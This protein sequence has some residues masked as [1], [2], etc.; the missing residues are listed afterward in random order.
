MLF[1]VCVL[2]GFVS[3]ANG[4]PLHSTRA[5]LETK[6]DDG[7][8][9]VGWYS[10]PQVRGTFDLLL[11]CLTT[12]SLCAWTAYH[13]NVHAHRS[14]WKVLSHRA[15]WML[16]A[17]LF[18]EV[19]LWCAWEQWWAA[20]KLGNEINVL[21]EGA[22]DGVGS[23]G[24]EKAECDVCD[25]AEGDEDDGKMSL[26]DY[27][28]NLLFEENGS[29]PASQPLTDSREQIAELKTSGP[30]KKPVSP[31]IRVRKVFKI[32]RKT[33]EKDNR[34]ANWTTSQAFFALSGGF[35]VPSSNFHPSPQ[36]TLTSPALVFLARHG[37]LPRSSPTAVA[38]K[39]KADTI[40]K[41]LVCIQAGWFFIQCIARTAQNLPLTLLEIHVLAHV[42]CAFAMYAVWAAKPYDVGSPILCEDERVVQLAAF[43][44]L[45]VDKV[46]RF[47]ALLAYTIFFVR[48]HADSSST[49][50]AS[51]VINIVRCAHR[52]RK[53]RLWKP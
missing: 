28:L 38:D 49:S 31:W 40:A 4:L 26:D 19:V 43:W 1:L 51:V 32:P 8:E 21:G 23:G 35:A 13:P 52:S 27:H 22:F 15:T 16:I 25:L 17:V 53:T 3:R 34:P 10:T 37:L 50:N 9:T 42:L 45:Q 30:P 5:A 12:L 48:E 24:E 41:L 46:R 11:S 14:E 20:R 7:P 6:R 39:S 33:N 47:E 44:A 36:L 2:Y 18:P 29:P